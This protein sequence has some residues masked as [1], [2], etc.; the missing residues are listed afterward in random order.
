MVLSI[1][2]RFEARNIVVGMEHL[3]IFY[4]G[5]YTCTFWD[6]CMQLMDFPC[7]NLLQGA[8]CG[9]RHAFA[10]PLPCL[11]HA[12]AMLLP[13]LCHA[14]VF[15]TPGHWGVGGIKEVQRWRLLCEAPWHE[16]RKGLV[17]HI[18]LYKSR[19]AKQQFLGTKTSNTIKLSHDGS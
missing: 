4:N 14:F 7:E 9:F 13:C 2:L 12:F 11:C 19:F 15:R 10:M 8:C 18:S 16:W 17:L 5:T 6:D 1:K 3:V